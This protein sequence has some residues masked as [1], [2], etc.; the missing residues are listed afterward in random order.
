[1][2]E[3]GLPEILHPHI[4]DFTRKEAFPAFLVPIM[5]G[6][7][8]LLD[9]KGNNIIATSTDVLIN[10]RQ[11]TSLTSCLKGISLYVHT[12]SL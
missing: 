9:G 7:A 6:N 11:T 8:T 1:M 3:L 5:T 12:V 10:I 4:S 2:K